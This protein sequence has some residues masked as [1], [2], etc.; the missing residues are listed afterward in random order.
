MSEDKGRREIEFEREQRREHNALSLMPLPVRIPAEWYHLLPK[1]L[2]LVVDSDGESENVLSPDV[3]K[4]FLSMW[5]ERL[6]REDGEYIWLKLGGVEA[7]E[8]IP[9]FARAV[10][11]KVK[12]RDQEIKE[13]G[14][15]KGVIDHWR[16]SVNELR[17]EDDKEVLEGRKE[18]LRAIEPLM[19]TVALSGA[20]AVSY[21]RSCENLY[22]IR[23]SVRDW[24][25][26]N[27]DHYDLDQPFGGR[28][29]ATVETRLH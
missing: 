28:I 26:R 4:A 7:F 14:G 24:M 27:R 13:S 22:R 29:E 21:Q 20:W 1:V 10:E 15:L 11:I 19:S 25:D 3:A 9:S 8:T 5:Q 12:G 17:D 2:P 6:M 16:T 18:I 23:E